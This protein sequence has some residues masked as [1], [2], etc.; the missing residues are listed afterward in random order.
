MLRWQA[1]CGMKCINLYK[2]TIRITGVHYR[3][4]K[5]K[6]IRNI[7][8]NQYQK[9]KMFSNYGECGVLLLK[10]NYSF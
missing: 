4:T 10:I 7:S 5:P 8:W 3:I 6:K 2:D 9:I 1:V